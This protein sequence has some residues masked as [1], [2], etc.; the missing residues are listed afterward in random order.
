MRDRASSRGQVRGQLSLSVVEAG[1]GVV[2]LV[3]V[4]AGFALSLPDASAETAQLDAY[5]AD[6]GT[7]LAGEM[8]RHRDTSRLVEV[9]RSVAGFERERA[10]LE[11]RVER[12][13]PENLLFRIRTPHGTVGFARPDGIS[14]GSARV[15]TPAGAVTVWVWYA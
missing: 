8:P 6:V 14:L 7:V 2:L 4:T 5:A 11:R 12:I 3:A 1:V 15:V 9:S 10:S 13:P